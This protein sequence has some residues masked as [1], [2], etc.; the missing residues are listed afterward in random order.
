MA[1]A[2]TGLAQPPPL[3][4]NYVHREEA[5][6]VEVDLRFDPKIGQYSTLTIFWF[7][8][9]PFSVAG[10]DWQATRAGVAAIRVAERAG[11]GVSVLLQICAKSLTERRRPLGP[12]SRPCLQDLRR[13]TLA[14]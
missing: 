2:G 8:H 14:L 10:W 4:I 13:H 7:I 12:A 1:T 3:C 6:R 11:H 5:G 9:E